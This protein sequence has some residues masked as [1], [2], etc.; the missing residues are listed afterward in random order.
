MINHYSP[1]ECDFSLR[2]Y[3]LLSCLFWP[4]G[5]PYLVTQRSRLLGKI[6]VVCHGKPIPEFTLKKRQNYTM[7]GRQ[8][9][10][11]RYTFEVTSRRPWQHQANPSIIIQLHSNEKPDQTEYNNSF[12][13]AAFLGNC[14]KLTA[15]E[16]LMCL[17]EHFDN[18]YMSNQRTR[19]DLMDKN[20]HLST[21]IVKLRHLRTENIQLR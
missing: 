4:F 18:L 10:I 6:S 5:S 13:F 15:E 3:I 12:C 9:G 2:S 20:A 21:E 8:L 7:G 17:I 11:A 1:I 14:K 19:S 16:Q